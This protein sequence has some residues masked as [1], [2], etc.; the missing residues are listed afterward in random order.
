MAATRRPYRTFAPRRLEKLTRRRPDSAHHHLAT[1]QNQSHLVSQP[2]PACSSRRRGRT[3]GSSLASADRARLDHRA[4]ST[5]A[6]P[7]RTN[8]RSTTRRRRRARILRGATCPTRYAAIL[9]T[10]EPDEF[11]RQLLPNQAAARLLSHRRHL[12]SADRDDLDAH[13]PARRALPPTLWA[14]PHAALQP[15][16]VG[17]HSAA[18]TSPSATQHG[19]EAW[20]LSWSQW[21]GA[22][23]LKTTE[24]KQPG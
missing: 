2:L 14:L 21:P 17:S 7:S 10:P 18:S 1:L 4:G 19:R 13:R 22:W 9:S 11:R 6:Y 15:P 5:L 24:K 20:S 8:P 16:L 12:P 3:C 23:S